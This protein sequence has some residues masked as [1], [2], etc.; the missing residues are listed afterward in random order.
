MRRWILL[1][2]LLFAIAPAPSPSYSDQPQSTYFPLVIGRTPTLIHT[3][4]S[5]CATEGDLIWGPMSSACGRR[6]AGAFQGSGFTPGGSVT[7]WVV[8]SI[9]YTFAVITADAGG[10]F[11]RYL[12]RQGCTADLIESSY[13]YFAKDETTGVTASVVFEPGPVIGGVWSLT[14][15]PGPTPTPVPCPW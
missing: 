2:I 3:P 13:T 8:P 12:R 6:D 10:G 15:T 11:T 9:S 1:L 5:G 7:R 14:P 4:S